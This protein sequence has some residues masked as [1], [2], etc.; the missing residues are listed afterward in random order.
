M[1][2]QVRVEIIISGYVQKAGY[3]DLIQEIAI[4]LNLTGLVKNLENKTVHVLCEGDKKSIESFV[5]RINIQEYPI[6]VKDIKISYLTATNEFEDFSI[7]REEDMTTAISERMDLAA[8]YLR[9]TKKELGGKIDGLGT[10]IDG[11]GNKIDKV[12]EK[13]GGLGTELGT[14]IDGLGDKM[15]GVGGKIDKVSEKIDSMHVDINQNFST[16]SE[17]YDKIG[18]AT[19]DILTEVR[20]K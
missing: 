18:Q 15:V 9:E 2:N 7:V 1:G 14:K 6:I 17:K 3:R 12:S 5:Q 19:N 13:I 11:L 20:K 16:M 8:R 10:K 4:A